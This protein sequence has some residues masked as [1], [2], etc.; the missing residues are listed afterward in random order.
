MSKPE[1]GQVE[2][3]L[4]FC[5]ESMKGGNLLRSEIFEDETG[6]ERI[7][8]MVDYGISGTKKFDVST[9]ELDVA[10]KRVEPTLE[11]LSM[12][13][14]KAIADEMNVSVDGK[15]NHVKLIVAIRK[16]I[17]AEAETEVAE[18]VDEFVEDEGEGSYEG[19]TKEELI[20]TATS[21]GVKIMKS[22]TKEKIIDELQVAE[23]GG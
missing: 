1:K 19:L 20:Q 3:L 15:P 12:T 5:G 16:R 11:M 8:A 6:E 10:N 7:V 17:K 23:A 22:W 2:E 13:A 9:R 4:A 18:S 21:K 14:L